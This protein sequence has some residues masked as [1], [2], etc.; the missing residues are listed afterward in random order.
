[1]KV[2][3]KNLIFFRFK[4]II[5]S[6]NNGKYGKE[7]VIENMIKRNLKINSNNFE[8]CTGITKYLGKNIKFYQKIYFFVMCK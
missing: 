8:L 4:Y 3:L 1:M 2:D 5:N 7:I 6:R